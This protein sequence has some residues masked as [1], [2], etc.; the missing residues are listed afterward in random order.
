MYAIVLKRQKT[1]GDSLLLHTLTEAG[2]LQ[3]F[4]LPGILKSKKRSSFYFIAATIWNFTTSQ[5]ERDILIPKESNLLVAPVDENASYSEL[6]MLASLLKPTSILRPGAS[7]NK[8][9]YDKL[10]RI[11]SL[12]PAFDENGRTELIN[13]FYLF[14]IY[15]LGSLQISTNC[16]SCGVE[17]QKQDVYLPT[18]GAL[19]QNCYSKLF[20]TRYE[21]IPW[22]WV[23]YYFAE[24]AKKLDELLQ[25]RESQVVTNPKLY[26]SE[27]FKR[28]A[29]FCEML[30]E[31]NLK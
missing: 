28:S 1:I 2:Q 13:H 5:S 15:S 31:S 19:C 21:Y 4:K 29:D 17:L 18:E 3:T 24:Y 14:F 27:N 12:W 6:N 20:S 26:E 22:G 9:I 8:A 7:P 23:N 10:F 25:T 30:F 11:I 16:S